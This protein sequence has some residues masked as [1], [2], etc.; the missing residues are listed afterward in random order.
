MC[1]FELPL[2]ENS[3]GHTYGTVAIIEFSA[4]D[5]LDSKTSDSGGSNAES[6]LP[7]S[8]SGL[9]AL[10]FRFCEHGTGSAERDIFEFD[11]VRSCH[12]TS[13]RLVSLDR[14]TAS[15]HASS[16]ATCFS[17]LAFNVRIC[18]RSLCTVSVADCLIS[19]TLFTLA[20][21]ASR[22]WFITLLERERSADRH[23][24]TTRKSFS[25]GSWSS[26]VKWSSIH[27]VR[28]FR[29]SRDFT[30]C[31]SAKPASLE[32]TAALFL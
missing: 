26:D 16:V 17:R 31:S 32:N 29:D 5:R 19:R 7:L 15:R 24:N 13:S 27:I 10:A 11:A 2:A 30:S 20:F 8:H 6:S 4:I 18:A 14:A 25:A 22:S 3:P 21:K 1:D 12:T 23:S 9:S 28:Y